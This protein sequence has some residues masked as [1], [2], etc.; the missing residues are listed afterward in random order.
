MIGK[1][2]DVR[3]QQR[4]HSSGEEDSPLVEVL[5]GD[6]RQR[7]VHP[8]LHLQLLRLQ[9]TM[10]EGVESELL[11]VFRTSATEDDH[12]VNT[13]TVETHR[14]HMHAVTQTHREHTM[15]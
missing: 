7:A 8:L 10:A 14:E 15:S 9:W 12:P 3:Q 2:S 13:H 4:R 1:H 5:W 11:K 6:T